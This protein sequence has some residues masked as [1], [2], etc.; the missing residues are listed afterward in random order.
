MNCVFKVLLLSAF[1]ALAACDS[2]AVAERLAMQDSRTITRT[3]PVESGYAPVNGLSMYYEL[4]G[5]G[6]TPLVVLHGALMTI[7][8]S[9]GKV[10]PSLARTRQV[11]AIE[12][13]GHGRTADIDRPLAYSRWQMT[14]PRQL[15]IEQADFL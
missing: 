2:D 8:S 10:L 9:F 5:D 12:Q 13:Q 4:H 7:E 1:A 11:I 15:E 14:P 3:I 6:G